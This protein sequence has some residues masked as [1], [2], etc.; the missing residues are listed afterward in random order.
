MSEQKNYKIERYTKYGLIILVIILVILAV[1]FVIQFRSLYRQRIVHS[2]ESRISQILQR[3]APLPTSDIG[4][5]R[6]WMTFNYINRLFS[7]PADYLKSK[8]NITDLHY[9]QLTIYGYAKN[10]NLD[11][12]A[13]L[14]QVE[15]AI[16]GY[17]PTKTSTSTK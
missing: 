9:P 14:R 10:L 12:A 16:S 5:I 3:R 1:F 6:S 15:N 2:W 17:N 8:L 11:Q 7:L 4:V 13:F